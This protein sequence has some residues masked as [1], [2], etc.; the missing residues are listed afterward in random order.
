MALRTAGERS[1]PFMPPG[2]EPSPVPVGPQRKARAE[3]AEVSGEALWVL[4][5]GAK[6]C[7]RRSG[8]SWWGRGDHSGVLAMQSL[9]SEKLAALRG[10]VSDSL[11]LCYFFCLAVTPAGG[12]GNAN[13]LQL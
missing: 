11:G 4:G 5:R 13:Y 12:G 2:A 1:D 9:A 8:A 7:A 3:G 6:G 10:H